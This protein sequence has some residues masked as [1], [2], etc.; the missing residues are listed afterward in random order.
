VYLEV[1]IIF[2]ELFKVFEFIDFRANILLECDQS[3]WNGKCPVL[4]K[5]KPMI[6]NI[7]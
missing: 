6:Q 7:N 4:F 1:E 2:A 3:Q 5:L